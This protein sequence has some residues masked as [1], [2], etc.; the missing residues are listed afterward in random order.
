M[1]ADPNVPWDLVAEVK[2]STRKTQIIEYIDEEPA[3][4]SELA[5]EFDIQ[6][7]SVSNI[8]RELKKTEPP[9]IECLTPEQ[10]HHRLYGL[11]ETGA[12]V[13]EHI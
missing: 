13:R 7:G 6:T 8:F 9:L 4:A 2:R 3:C 10:P 1:A 11:T 5:D 12:E